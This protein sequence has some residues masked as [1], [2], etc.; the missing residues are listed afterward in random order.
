MCNLLKFDALGNNL[1]VRFHGFNR[2]RSSLGG[3]FTIL[4]FLISIVTIGFFMNI[5]LAG[6]EIK[7]ISSIVKYWDSQNI[8]VNNSFKFAVDTRYSGEYVNK[9]TWEINAYFVTISKQQNA[10][11]YKLLETVECKMSDWEEVEYQYHI[12]N[13]KSAQ[14]FNTTGLS[15]SGNFNTEIFQYITVQYSLK[16]NETNQSNAIEVERAISR[17]Q[18]VASLY[19][20]E[21]IFEIKSKDY[22]SK[23]FI[24]SVNINLT[25]FDA[26]EM[27][28]LIS[29][30]QVITNEDNLIVNHPTVH[31]MYV[32]AL[33]REKVSVRTFGAHNSLA[34]N[35]ISSNT[36]NVSIINFMTFSEM[37]ARIGGILQNLI[38]LLFLT[39]YIKNYWSFEYYKFSEVV[40]RLKSDAKIKETI[41]HK[42]IKAE[43]VLPKSSDLQLNK[44]K[45][46][47]HSQ[48]NRF[49]TKLKISNDKT[50]IKC[51]DEVCKSKS[52]SE[53]INIYRL[54]E[55]DHIHNPLTKNEFHSEARVDKGEN[56][57]FIK[58]LMD[59]SRLSQ[60]TQSDSI[61]TAVNLLGQSDI[62]FC[63]FI[64]VKYFKCCF[65][66][67]SSLASEALKKGLLTIYEITQQY[68]NHTLEIT[69]FDKLK[70]DMDMIKFLVFEPHELAL[71]EH[72]PMVEGFFHFENFNKMIMHGPSHSVSKDDHREKILM[73]SLSEILS[74]ESNSKV[75]RFI[76]SIY[77]L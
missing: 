19:F 34:F 76:E 28:I 71:F 7:Q 24:N 14:C 41:K 17:E 60:Q 53:S 15:L 77:R 31:D 47:V 62:S 64:S 57:N 43:K 33:A 50:Y 51:N 8:T 36:R 3:F 9:D 54:S 22:S 35:L 66:G 5:Y 6:T 38:T 72:I 75:Y 74:H 2:M 10:I 55:L 48:L 44:K 11:K 20:V 67:K 61:Y 26:K 29:S 37:L 73:N 39:N 45:T 46:E 27:D 25:Y 18:P 30:D 16:I 13:I 49:S 58:D 12:L 32:I 63:Q 52:N 59:S 68:L 65:K 1:G 40:S 21:G 23:L 4:L 56:L 70:F 42:L 69:D